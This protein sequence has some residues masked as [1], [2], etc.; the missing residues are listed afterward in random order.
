MRKRVRGDK[1]GVIGARKLGDGGFAA[2]GGF[3][4][5]KRNAEEA[6]RT[7]NVSGG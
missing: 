1:R 6:R 7:G 5:A 3:E 2:N 4:A